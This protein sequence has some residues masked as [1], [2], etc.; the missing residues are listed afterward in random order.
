MEFKT[1]TKTQKIPALGLGTWKMGG[2]MRPDHSRDDQY[3]NS[4]KYAVEKGINHIDT[5]EIY[6]AG[7]AEEL[8]GKAIKKFDRK[9]LFITT[10]VWPTHLSYE[11][12]LMAC[13]GSLKR[14]QTS[15]VDLYL[16]HWPN[17]LAKMEN[18][19]RA[20]DELVSQHKIR[21]VGVSNFSAKQIQ[22][23]Q[24]HTK[25]KIVNDQVQ[26][27][28]M[29]RD[30][31]EELLGLCQKQNIILT[32]YTPIAKGAL[33]QGQFEALDTIAKKYHKTPIQVALR[34][35]LEKPNV[36]VIPKASSP[37]H[38]D[39]LLGSLGWKMK[40]EDQEYLSREF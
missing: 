36:I 19:M 22:N 18:T 3:I 2:E 24:Q 35:L 21:N 29:H 32:A 25:N 1:I 40:K 34:W 9:K 27:S 39:E 14:L 13:E 16:I 17:P 7:R 30:P 5:A 8:I 10:K 37:E 6:G 11:N 33:V 26:Y 20:F 15:Y 4:I 38:V 12:V 23:A 31:E 28:L